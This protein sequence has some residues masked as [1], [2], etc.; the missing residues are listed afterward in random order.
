MKQTLGRAT[1]VVTRGYSGSHDGVG[2]GPT[3]HDD[4]AA[5][6]ALAQAGLVPAYLV[7]LYDSIGNVTRAD[8][9]DGCFLDAASEVLPRLQVYGAVDV[10]TDPKVAD[11][12]RPTAG[13]GCAGGE[14]TPARQA[15][16]GRLLTR[17][18]VRG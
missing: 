16:S 15:S 6:R 10:G 2:T 11:D 7:T 18:A 8:A 14:R 9:G 4:Q 5:A 1:G 12:L 13:Y 3:D 17:P